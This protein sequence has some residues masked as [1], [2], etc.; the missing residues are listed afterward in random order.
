M[1]RCLYTVG[2]LY[3]MPGHQVFVL[4]G[5]AA[6]RPAVS[7]NPLALFRRYRESFHVYR[8]SADGG[9]LTLEIASESAE[10]ETGEAPVGV[11]LAPLLRRRLARSVRR[12]LRRPRR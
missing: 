9:R 4:G 7:R 12:A 1:R 3:P 2:A 5:L 11:A 8:V 10:E 6:E